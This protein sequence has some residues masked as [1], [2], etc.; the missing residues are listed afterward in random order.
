MSLAQSRSK[1]VQHGWSSMS[2]WGESRDEEMEMHRPWRGRAGGP[3]GEVQGGPEAC[4]AFSKRSGQG[5]LSAGKWRDPTPLLVGSL[6]AMSLTGV[7]GGQLG[8][9]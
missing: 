8:N 5:R 7:A 9:H 4:K 1:G 2:K 6:T 3:G